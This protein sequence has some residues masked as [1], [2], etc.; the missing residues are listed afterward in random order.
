LLT[1]YLHWVGW[2][3]HRYQPS[4]LFL[5]GR[6]DPNFRQARRPTVSVALPRVISNREKRRPKNRDLVSRACAHLE[7]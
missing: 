4:W 1:G 2:Y 7:S 5:L 6:V 3:V